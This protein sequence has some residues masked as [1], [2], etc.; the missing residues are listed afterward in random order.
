MNELSIVLV[1]LEAVTLVAA[2]LLVRRLLDERERERA[3]WDAERGRLLDR[4]MAKTYE[5]YA[6]HRPT[7]V[8]QV[9]TQIVDDETEAAIAERIR[10][11][12]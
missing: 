7:T 6:L 8:T 12:S 10:V 3:L 2:S 4:V 9:G 1:A 5:E 11:V